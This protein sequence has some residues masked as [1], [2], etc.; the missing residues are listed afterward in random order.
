MN[1]TLKAIAF[2]ACVAALP[3]A[4]LN[5]ED[6]VPPLKPGR[7]VVACSNLEHDEARLAQLGGAPVDYWEGN[8]VNGQARYVTD[9]LKHRD[10][11]FVFDKRVPL[12]PWLYPTRWAQRLEF[13][14]LVCYPTSRL[15]T[16]PDYQL[17]GEGGRIPRM[18]RP[19][20]APKLISTPEYL[21][22]LGIEV[23]MLPDPGPAKLPVIVYSHGLGG[24]PV[25]KGYIDIAVQLAAQ[26][27]MVAA[28][29]HADA[30]ISPVKIED[31][32][33]FLFAVANLTRKLGV[34][35]ET[36]LRRANDKFR[37]RFTAIEARITSRG[38]RMQ[39]LSLDELEAEWQEVK[40]IDR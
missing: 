38:E 29:F 2:L 40:R 26:G 12:E 17:P 6:V 28:V 3:A 37:K 23:D 9:I 13:A 30:R 4:A 21:Q 20:E 33:D 11:A 39:D 5:H 8:E 25:G 35:P 14:A 19:G 15:N 7:F 34:E 36:A 32:G 27:Y 22:T 1:S 18:Q 10:T 24:S 31:F 16:D